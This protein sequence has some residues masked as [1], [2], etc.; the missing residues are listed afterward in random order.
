[1]PNTGPNP[2]SRYISYDNFGW[3]LLT[4]LQL[5]TMD[6]WESIYN[7]VSNFLLI[8]LFC[9]AGRL[10]KDNGKLSLCDQRDSNLPLR[11]GA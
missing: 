2:I 6:Y 11:N 5:V 9:A 10:R 8:R 4:S 7:S 1:M 3:A